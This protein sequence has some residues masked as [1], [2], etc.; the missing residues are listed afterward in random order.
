MDAFIIW[1]SERLQKTLPGK[2]AQFKMV[3]PASRVL[4]LKPIPNPR[5]SSVLLLL[6]KRNAQW[7][8]VFIKRPEYNGYHSG[9]ISLPG[10]KMELAD[11]DLKFTAL[12]ETFEEV[13]VNSNDVSVIGKLST[14][15]IPISGF[16]VEP[17][18]GVIAYEPNFIPEPKE[19]SKIITTEIDLFVAEEL[20]GSFK[21]SRDDFSFEAPY[22]KLAGEKLWGATAMMISEFEELLREYLKNGASFKK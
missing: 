20:K 13:G 4:R 2:E 17:Y 14:V 1:L 3:P 8:T 12:R 9:Q 10:G 6:F 19:V 15:Q 16:I 7:H 11:P 22:Y 18:I 21:Y 5:K